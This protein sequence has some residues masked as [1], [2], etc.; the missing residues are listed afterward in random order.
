MTEHQSYI[1]SD[2]DSCEDCNLPDE[3]E[4]FI[5]DSIYGTPFLE[6]YQAYSARFCS[7]ECRHS[8]L[9][10]RPGNQCFICVECERVILK[11]N[12]I[13][14][15]KPQYR[16]TIPSD[17]FPCLPVC[18]K[19]YNDHIL[20]NGQE[21]FEFED[22]H[23]NPRMVVDSGGS[24]G[25]QILEK[26]GYDEKSWHVMSRVEDCTE[27]NFQALKLM[28]NGFQVIVNIRRDDDKEVSICLYAK[29]RKVKSK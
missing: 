1:N 23:G 25:Y 8:F 17:E 19:C 13:N 29:Q 20:K 22:E 10:D 28:D 2:A 18:L 12:Q 16:D 5:Y 21:R 15:L 4:D 9:Y 14:T 27:C 11:R 24:F 6:D 7:K 26:Y 3:N